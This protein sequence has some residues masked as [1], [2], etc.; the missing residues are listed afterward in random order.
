MI[1]CYFCGDGVGPFNAE[2]RN[3]WRSSLGCICRRLFVGALFVRF[4]SRPVAQLAVWMEMEDGG[5]P[6][7]SSDEEMGVPRT[8]LRTDSDVRDAVALLETHSVLDS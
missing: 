5:D 3:P 4:Y 8:V 1:A 7:L 6:V 2:I